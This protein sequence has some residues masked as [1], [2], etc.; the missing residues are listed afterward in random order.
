MS[1][2]KQN[3]DFDVIQKTNHNRVLKWVQ[4]KNLK[5]L[6]NVILRGLTCLQQTFD[7]MSHMAVIKI[8]F[9]TVALENTVSNE[10]LFCNVQK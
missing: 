3:L 10:M 6:K 9:A 2:V 8:L 7:S 1:K 4:P 5:Y